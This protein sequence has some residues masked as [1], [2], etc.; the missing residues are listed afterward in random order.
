LGVNTRTN[1]RNKSR[2]N[3]FFNALAGCRITDGEVKGH[4]TE[5]LGVIENTCI[6]LSGKHNWGKMNGKQIAELLYQYKLKLC[7]GL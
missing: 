3:A 5:E 4:T 1:V 7:F 6:K 2:S